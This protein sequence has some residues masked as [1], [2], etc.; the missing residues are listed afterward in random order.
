MGPYEEMVDEFL[1]EFVSRCNNVDRLM[2]FVHMNGYVTDSDLYRLI[3][4]AYHAWVKVKYEY[5]LKKVCKTIHAAAKLG[6]SAMDKLKKSLKSG[7]KSCRIA[8]RHGF[9]EYEWH[10][11][12]SEEE[13]RKIQMWKRQLPSCHD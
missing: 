9:W 3:L 1:D 6:P 13:K 11:G 7:I 12:S 8:M 2:Y 5:Q 4:Q 10:R